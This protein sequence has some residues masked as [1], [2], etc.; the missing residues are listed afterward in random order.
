[1]KKC[2]IAQANQTV[3]FLMQI[4]S[5]SVQSAGHLQRISLTECIAG[6][7]QTDLIFLPPFHSTDAEMPQGSWCMLE[8][9]N[10]GLH[11][12]LSVKQKKPVPPSE[13]QVLTMPGQSTTTKQCHSAGG[14][15][16]R[17][18]RKFLGEN[19]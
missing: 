6:Y 17:N 14:M 1:M 16:G 4:V 5:T 13:L 12:S 10:N 19:I 15:V 18:R 2:Q 7:C 11:P 8:T 9:G 3:I